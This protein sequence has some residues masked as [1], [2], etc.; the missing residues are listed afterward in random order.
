MRNDVHY[1]IHTT[2]GLE[3]RASHIHQLVK[4]PFTEAGETFKYR[5]VNSFSNI[6]WPVLVFLCSQAFRPLALHRYIILLDYRYLD[7]PE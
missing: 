5:C 3:S 1:H 4:E 6:V 7:I 2:R